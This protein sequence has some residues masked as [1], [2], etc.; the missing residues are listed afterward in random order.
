[1]PIIFIIALLKNERRRSRHPSKER[2]RER[3]LSKK[4]GDKGREAIMNKA[5]FLLVSAF[6]VSLIA[7]TANIVIIAIYAPFLSFAPRV[8][9]RPAKNSVLHRFAIKI[10]AHNSQGSEAIGV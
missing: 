2:Y 9:L 7:A 6:L 3:L 10:S 1:M 4:K 5:L 8:P